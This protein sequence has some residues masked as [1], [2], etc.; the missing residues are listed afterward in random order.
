MTPLERLAQKGWVDYWRMFQRYHRYSIEGLERLEDDRAMLAAG[1]HGRPIA[2]DMCM[3]TVAVYDRF[4]YLPHGVVHRGLESAPLLKAFTDALGFVTDDG[5]QLQRAVDRGEHIV[6]TPGGGQ[7]GCRSFRERYTVAWQGRLGYVRLAAKY[8]LPI[9]PVAGAGADD[10]YIGLNNAEALGRRLGIPRR[11]AFA[12]W[13]GFGPL[14]LYPFSPPF[15]VRIR[16]FV[17]EPIDPWGGKP[18]PKASQAMI[19]NV[20]ARVVAAVQGLLDHARAWQNGR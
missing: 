7:E 10:T 19:E 20:H 1:Y 8:G 5:P 13:L 17:G 14:G 2:L 12:L 9:V 15:P 4:G 16:Q 3:F 6:V 11:W 18:Q